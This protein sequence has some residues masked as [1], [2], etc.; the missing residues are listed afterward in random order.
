LTTKKVKYT[1]SDVIRSSVIPH[2]LILNPERLDCLGG[3]VESVCE[4]SEDKG[5]SAVC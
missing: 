5:R 4:E 3:T 1:G 2:I